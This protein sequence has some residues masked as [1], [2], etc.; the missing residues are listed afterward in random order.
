MSEDKRKRAIIALEDEVPEEEMEVNTKFAEYFAFI[1]RKEGDGTTESPLTVEKL[2]KCKLCVDKSV[3]YNCGKNPRTSMSRHLKDDHPREYGILH[4]KHETPAKKK[5]ITITDAFH[6]VN[7]EQ[8]VNHA[9]ESLVELF[10]VHSLALSLVDSP[11]FISFISAVM[12]CNGKFVVPGRTN[13]KKRIIDPFFSML[14][15][16]SIYL[17]QMLHIHNSQII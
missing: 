10:V 11:E 15:F 7:H 9:M 6:T 13:L 16:L 12:L 2:V 8:A 17:P 14:L 1:E 4:S 3:T 5:Q